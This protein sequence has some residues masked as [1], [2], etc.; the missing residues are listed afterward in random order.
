M[1][2]YLLSKTQEM[3]SVGE[4]VKKRKHYRWECKL[5]ESLWETF[6]W[7]LKKL[8]IEFPYDFVEGFFW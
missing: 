8:K 2:V 5:V 6:W 1:L 7:F 3:T 4:V